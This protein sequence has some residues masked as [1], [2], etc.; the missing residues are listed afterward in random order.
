M[1]D[2]GLGATISFGT[3]GF[4]ASFEEIGSTTFDRPAIETTHLGTT[5]QKTY[6]VGDLYEPGQF[7]AIF[8]WD[9][10]FSTFPP[11]NAAAETIT[12]SYPLKSGESVNATLAGSGFLIASEGPAAR[13]GEKMMGRVTVKWDGV[14][15]VSYTAGS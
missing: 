3:S 6:M 12:I 15:E 2:T 9:Q 7:D 14:T 5:N 11:I 8:Q 13:V 1:A 4:T 10:S